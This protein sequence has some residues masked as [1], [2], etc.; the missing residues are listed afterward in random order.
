MTGV[1]TCALPILVRDVNTIQSVPFRFTANS[2]GT[3]QD[4][5]TGLVWQQVAYFDSLTWENALTY[6]DTCT[7][8]GYSDWRLPN[9]KEMES[10]ND[11]SKINPSIDSTFFTNIGVKKYWSSTTLPNQSVRAWYLD[12]RFGITTYLNKTSR[13]NLL[14]VRG[15]GNPGLSSL[16]EAIQAERLLAYPNPFHNELHLK[17]GFEKDDFILT[18]ISG[19]IIYHGS[20]FGSVDFSGLA[21]GSYI[22]TKS[23]TPFGSQLIIKY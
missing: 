19:N 14:L 10:I 7:W 8:A 17:S 22:L 3:I 20:A 23:G 16:G 2:N 1:Q 21:P 15:D 4:H 18:D 5:I 13:L 6:A 9:I 11:E 12:T